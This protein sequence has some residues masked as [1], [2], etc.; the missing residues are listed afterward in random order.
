MLIGVLGP[1]TCC[2][3]H[4]QAFEPWKELQGIFLR[5]KLCNEVVAESFGAGLGARSRFGCQELSW[6]KICER[7]KPQGQKC[8]WNS[9]PGPR[10]RKPPGAEG[11]TG[12]RNLPEP[13]GYP[14]PAFSPFQGIP[15]C[16]QFAQFDLLGTVPSCW[17]AAGGTSW[18]RVWVLKAGE[19][20]SLPWISSPSLWSSLIPWDFHG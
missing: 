9:L 19:N 10:G 14:G 11:K 12:T 5:G 6:L 16:S 4:L 1:L 15:A 18:G 20:Y 3:C 8:P 13:L 2:H 17:A 7:K